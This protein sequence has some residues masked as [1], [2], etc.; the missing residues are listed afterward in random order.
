M[1]F[2]NLKKCFCWKFLFSFHL[3]LLGTVSFAG[4]LQSLSIMFIVFNHLLK[5]QDGLFQVLIALFLLCKFSIYGS[6]FEM[7]V[8]IQWL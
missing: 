7:N 8:Y 3:L 2:Y 6:N 1:N 5:V 4:S